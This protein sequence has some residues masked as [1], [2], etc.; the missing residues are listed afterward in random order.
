[1]VY[2]KI[3]IPIACTDQERFAPFFF[4]CLTHD[5]FFCKLSSMHHAKTKYG[6]KNHSSLMRSL[7]ARMCI[8][9]GSLAEYIE[10]VSLQCPDFSIEL[11]YRC[12]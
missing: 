9:M 6:E 7:A 12:G 11:F 5:T 8:Y 3:R 4:K 2:F 10:N 1:M